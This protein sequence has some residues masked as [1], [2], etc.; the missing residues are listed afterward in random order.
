MCEAGKESA[1]GAS[2]ERVAAIR[3]SL[4]RA[5][6]SESMQN[7]PQLARF[8]R[9]IVEETL[10]G[11][12]AELKGYTI[13]TQ[14]LGRPSDF[15]PQI[16]PIVRVEA[17]RLRR[18]LD[19]YY[20][21]EG[22]RDPIRLR[23]PRGAYVPEFLIS[24]E[25]AVEP[26]TAPPE[27]E[28]MIAMRDARRI[29][30]A[31]A[32]FVGLIGFVLAAAYSDPHPPRADKLAVVAPSRSAGL[33]IV[34][35][36]PIS[37][38]GSIPDWF[39]PTRFRRSLS[40][41]FARFDEIEVIDRRSDAALSRQGGQPLE[42]SHLSVSVATLAQ[43]LEVSVQLISQ[44]D[45]RILWSRRFNQLKNEELR[46]REL[47]MLIAAT[48]AQPS[49]VLF[50]EIGENPDAG[51]A[52]GCISITFAYWA[53]PSA[54][55]HEA[56]RSCLTQLIAAGRNPAIAHALVSLVYLDEHR[57]G[58]NE[59]PAALARA[60][61]AAALAVSLNSESARAHQA[62]MAALFVSGDREGALA[63]GARAVTLN[64]ADSE[65][66]ADFGSKLVALGRY[67]A[68]V[69]MM[70]EARHLASGIAPR[71][72][73]FLFLSAYMRGDQSAAASAFSLPSGESNA[74]GLLGR[75]IAAADAGD[76]SRAAA[77]MEALLAVEP[78]FLDDPRRALERRGMPEAIVA[79]L[80]EGFD[81][82][83]INVEVLP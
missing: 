73:F 26:D 15:D 63:A 70:A 45:G 24:E 57:M 51:S 32:I 47:A 65:I 68:G 44:P 62:L 5:I 56:A 67:A 54:A 60:L 6:D 40:H 78:D 76:A 83:G 29:Y 77:L 34:V 35:I 36:D 79:R 13:A 59:R 10:A 22:K 11:R 48:V 53:K 72:E 28:P 25:E 41:A 52:A 69:E 80:L 61:Q 42:A 43:E 74:L 21:N 7:A 16:D 49:G 30:A 12:S 14:A 64:P 39:S 33:P 3:D 71:Y 18:V 46:D 4:E 75:A 17:M 8:L 55:A 58:Y 82:T 31:V 50:R 81:R 37:V 1:Q 27:A 2:V 66:L 9:F 23:V 19:A 38:D 20:E